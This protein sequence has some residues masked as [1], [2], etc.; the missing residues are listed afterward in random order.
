MTLGLETQFPIS[1]EGFTEISTVANF[2][3]TKNLELRLRHRYLDSHP[4]LDDSN[5]VDL[6]SYYRLNDDW[7]FGFYQQWEL[8]DGTLERQQY[9]INRNFDSW[10]ASLGLLHR[11]NREQEEFGILFSFTLREFPSLNLPLSLNTP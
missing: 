3:P 11:D 9:T 6:R 4:T 5:R 8:E 7:G 10:V 1:G 2:M